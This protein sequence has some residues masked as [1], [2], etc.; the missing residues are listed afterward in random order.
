MAANAQQVDMVTA[1]KGDNI[2]PS[3]LKVDRAEM[4]DNFYFLITYIFF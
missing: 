1:S 3:C 4:F 2:I